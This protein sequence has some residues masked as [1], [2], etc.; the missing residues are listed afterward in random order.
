MT[1]IILINRSKIKII[2]YKYVRRPIVYYIE[3]SLIIIFPDAVFAGPMPTM[4]NVKLSTLRP[5]VNH[6]HYEDAGL[7]Y[8]LGLF[9]IFLTFHLILAHLSG[10]TKCRPTYFS[11]HR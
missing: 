2:Q 1:K 5:I 3:G 8:G 11:P 10:F 9:Q 6:P 4:A 7:R